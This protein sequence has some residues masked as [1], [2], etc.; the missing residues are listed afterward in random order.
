MLAGD[1]AAEFETEGHDLVEGLAG[2]PGLVGVL[3]VEADGGVCVAVAR[4]GA[5]PDGQPYFSAIRS[6]PSSI[7][8]S[9]ERG[10]HTSSI[11]V[12]PLTASSAVSESRRACSRS[13][14]SA[15]SSAGTT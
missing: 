13:S 2:P 9:R 12:V 3:G 6:M 14:D 5:D 1:G 4:V 15:A 8:P 10:T 7:A 11:I